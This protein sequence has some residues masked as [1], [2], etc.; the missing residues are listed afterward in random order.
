M[1][2]NDKIIQTESG[3]A[4]VLN[5]F[6][7]NIVKKL[8]IKQYNVDDLTCENLNDRL[9]KAFVRYRNHPGIVA[10]KKCCNFRSHF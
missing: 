9:L 2:E 5:T 10:I 3:I 8:D 1:I 4:N 6:F 7:I